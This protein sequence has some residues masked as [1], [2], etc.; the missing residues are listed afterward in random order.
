MRFLAGLV[1]LTENRNLSDK[2]ETEWIEAH[3]GSR[4]FLVHPLY[5]GNLR[6]FLAISKNSELVHNSQF[7]RL[8]LLHIEAAL[9]AEIGNAV[10]TVL[11]KLHDFAIIQANNS[12]FSN[13]INTQDID[14]IELI[15]AGEIETIDNEHMLDAWAAFEDSFIQKVITEGTTL[16]NH[17]FAPLIGNFGVLDAAIEMEAAACNAFLFK[18][19]EGNPVPSVVC[20]ARDEDRPSNECLAAVG[21]FM[22]YY[23]HKKLHDA[24]T[25]LLRCS[26][27]HFAVISN[28]KS[29]ALNGMILA[30]LVPSN[31]C[32]ESCRDDL[33]ELPSWLVQARNESVRRISN[34]FTSPT[35]ASLFEYSKIQQSSQQIISQSE[36]FPSSPGTAVDQY[37]S[38]I[39]SGNIS[40]PIKESAEDMRVPALTPAPPKVP[41]SSGQYEGARA[42]RTHRVQ[43]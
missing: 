21:A 18:V 15:T 16:Y 30:I 43:K 10:H 14:L 41:K 28:W 33:S 20:S 23:I 26:D 1:N 37:V 3:L 5:V 13:S 22:K 24:Q 25:R 27:K 36:S 29:G 42:P 11:Q 2:G 35:C 6:A 17:A 7:G 12:S 32:K 31:V 19:L 9:G 34:I 39:Q 8:M 40:T 38:D 4:H